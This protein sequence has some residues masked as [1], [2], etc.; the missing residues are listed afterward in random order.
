[1]FIGT[2][3]IDFCTYSKYK[4][5]FKNSV[6]RR[7]SVGGAARSPGRGRGFGM[8]SAFAVAEGREHAWWWRAWANRWLLPLVW[9]ELTVL[10]VNVGWHPW[11]FQTPVR[12]AGRC[13][14]GVNPGGAAENRLHPEVFDPGPPD[15]GRSEPGS[16]EVP[17]LLPGSG[18][19]LCSPRPG[20]VPMPRGR[21]VPGRPLVGTGGRE[22][23]GTK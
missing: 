21:I 18:D 2:R 8:G 16:H 19:R 10:T 3:H 11:P 5:Q 20:Q 12:C 6:G 15:S 9:Q 4:K 7:C 22:S 1:M 23:P 14:P 13:A 17:G